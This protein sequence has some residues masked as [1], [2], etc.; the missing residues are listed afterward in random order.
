MPYQKR[1]LYRNY[2]VL[3]PVLVYVASYIHLA[4]YH[5]K[6]SILN[7]VIHEGGLY[8]FIETTLYASHFIGHIPVH[9]VLAFYF[10]GVFLYLSKVDQVQKSNQ[11][12]L[13]LLLILVIFLFISFLISIRWFGMDDT[14]SYIMQQKQSVVRM[15][16]GGSWNLHLPSTMMQFLLIPVYIY[17]ILLFFESPISVNKKGF[18]FISISLLLCV[19]VTYLVNNDLFRAIAHVWTEPR[20]LAHSV[21]ELATFP[22]TYYPIPLYIMLKYGE[23]LNITLRFDRVAK[24]MALIA[25]LFLILFAYQSVIPLQKGIGELAQKPS[26]AKGGELS[27]AYL[28]SSHYFEHFLDSVYFSLFCLILF[29]FYNGSKKTK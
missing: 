25:I 14:L 29:Y 17:V 1:S 20:Y 19:L 16:E 27:V 13:I 23:D 7:T 3:L 8:T 26:F 22:L 10:V 9:T 18:R 15:G 11:K 21:R 5:G 2:L 4:V 6:F 28:L 12:G 24:T